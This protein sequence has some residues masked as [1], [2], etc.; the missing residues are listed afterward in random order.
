MRDTLP[1][2]PRKIECGIMN[3]DINKNHGTHWVAF[4][5][6]NNYAE[7]YDSF[8]NLKPPLELVKYLY[9][10]PIYYNYDRHQA[11][12]TTNCG[13]LCLKFLRKYWK[14]HLYTE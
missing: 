8:G 11:F 2:K 13:H 12:G 3:L 6:H 10:L 14:K 1:S 5:K 9:N 7:Y 4:V